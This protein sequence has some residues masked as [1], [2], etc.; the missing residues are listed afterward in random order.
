MVVIEVADTGAGIPESLVPRVFER[1]VTT[2]PVGSGLGLWNV[3]SFAE[4]SGGFAEVESTSGVGTRFSLY[5]PR[6]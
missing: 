5:L 4:E 1:F 6:A 3:K 2:K